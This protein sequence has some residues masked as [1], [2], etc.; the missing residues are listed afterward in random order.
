MKRLLTIVSGIILISQLVQ[1]QNP[2]EWNGQQGNTNTITTAV[3]FLNIGP[4]ATS[5]GMGELGAATAPDAVSQHWNPAKYAFIE[6][7]M[8][9]AVS[10]SPWLRNLVNRY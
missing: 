3:P 10:Y 4:D 5:G 6:K 9:I 8:G 1:A 2:D 7:D